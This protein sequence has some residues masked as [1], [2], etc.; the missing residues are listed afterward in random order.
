MYYVFEKVDKYLRFKG[1]FKN[2]K[3]V[4]KNM[5]KSCPFDSETYIISTDKQNF[6]II[7]RDKRELGGKIYIN[8]QNQNL[9]LIKFSPVR[10]ILSGNKFEKND[11]IE[12][13]NFVNECIKKNLYF[14][15]I[16]F[17]DNNLQT[18]ILNKAE[19]YYDN[20]L[21]VKFIKKPNKFGIE[22]KF[23]RELMIWLDNSKN[24]DKVTESINNRLKCTVAYNVS[25]AQNA[26]VDV[27]IL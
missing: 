8:P 26:C 4:V 25:T 9:N 7:N 6:V 14:A 21:R 11:R 3:D 2:P 12:V 13:E 15:D 10:K 24:A 1:K 19:K 20:I 23:H 17:T 27:K 22:D 18:Y 16:I 5:Q